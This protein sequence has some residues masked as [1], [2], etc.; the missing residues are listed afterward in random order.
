MGGMGGLGGMGGMSGGRH[1]SSMFADDDDTSFFS[2]AGGGMPGGFSSGRPSSGARR[3]SSPGPRSAGPSEITKPFKVSLEDL[4]SGATKRLKVGRKLL[5]GGTE[6]KVLE[7]QVLP[8]W[9][10]GT[11]IR[12]PRAGNEQP[13]GEAQD[14]VFVVEE[15]PHPQFTREDNDLVCKVKLPLVEALAGGAAKKTVEALDGRKLQVAVPPG[16]VKPGQE[17][18]ITG[19]GMPIRKAGKKGDLIVRWD[20]VFPDRLTEAQKEGIRKVLG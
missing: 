10:E 7:I 6:D 12:F 4:Y 9:K 13:S 1:G 14:L 2:R 16:I 17:T 11:K 15:K 5:S 18:R 3:P 19:E 20:I 8:G